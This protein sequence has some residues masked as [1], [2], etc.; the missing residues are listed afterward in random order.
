MPTNTPRANRPKAGDLTGRQ[1]ATAAAENAEEQQK[2]REK[3][4]MIT[5]Q[6]EVK[7]RDEVVD[8]SNPSV[9]QVLK[10]DEVKD[11]RAHG[12][13]GLE[14][15]ASV[16]EAEV[17]TDVQTGTLEETEIDVSVP[18]VVVRVSEDVEMTYGGVE[19]KMVPGPKYRLA[20]YIAEHLDERGYIYH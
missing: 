10:D 4:A 14:D 1:R 18:T 6:N 17:G 12:T 8:L 3:M 19:F 16:E 5:A 11:P 7:L 13:D 2:A 15:E 9:P 20:K